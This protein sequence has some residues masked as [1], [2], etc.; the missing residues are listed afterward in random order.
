MREI[1]RYSRI[2]NHLTHHF[3]LDDY[4]YY[5]GLYLEFYED[6][7]P[8]LACTYIDDN[9]VGKYT[10]WHQN[11]TLFVQ[12]YY[13]NNRYHGEYKEWNKSGTLVVHCYMLHDEDIT[14]EIQPYLDNPVILKLKYGFNTNG[15]L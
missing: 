15:L 9:L 6:G 7:T 8:S 3:H 13:E 14:K 5:Q 12:T 2:G 1:K 4:N 10:R 11:G